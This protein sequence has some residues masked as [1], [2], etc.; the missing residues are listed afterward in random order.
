MSQRGDV[1]P[2]M[3]LKSREGVRRRFG[4]RS[5]LLVPG[6]ELYRRGTSDGRPDMS[7]GLS[8]IARSRK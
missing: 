1:F 8:R 2:S 5:W 7:S 3:R 6:G 4:I